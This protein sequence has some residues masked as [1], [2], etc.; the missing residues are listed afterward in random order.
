MNSR[1]G[2]RLFRAVMKAQVGGQCRRSLPQRKSTDAQ[3][4][5][6]TRSFECGLWSVSADL[7]NHCSCSVSVQVP[8]VDW[9]ETGTTND[10]RNLS[11]IVEWEQC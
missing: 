9:D 4:Q 1:T 2:G 6:L 11:L 8:L 5:R 10:L 3:H 7:F